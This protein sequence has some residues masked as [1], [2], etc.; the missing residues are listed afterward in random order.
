MG[1]LPGFRIQRRVLSGVGS[2]PQPGLPGPGLDSARHSH[3]R[4]PWERQQ[5]LLILSA[6]PC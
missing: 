6:L 2:A 5:A 4:R 1:T 3:A